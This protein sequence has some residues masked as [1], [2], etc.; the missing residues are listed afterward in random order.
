MGKLTT[1]PSPLLSQPRAFLIL[2]SSSST[3]SSSPDSSEHSTSFTRPGSRPSSHK[4]SAEVREVSAPSV[5]L[6]V[7]RRL[8]QS[9]SKFLSL[10]LMD[11]L[12]LL[13]GLRLAED[14][15]NVKYKSQCQDGWSR[16]KKKKK[17]KIKKGGGRGKKKKKKKKKS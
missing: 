14:K 13:E 3:S 2:K 16:G 9:R 17:K 1:R 8:S 6:E 15:S 10:E 7:Q 5:L 12:L 11:R 4:P